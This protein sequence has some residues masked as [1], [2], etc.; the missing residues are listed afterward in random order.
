MKLQRQAQRVGVRELKASLSGHLRR[1]RE[2]ESITVTD[3]G[4]PVAKLIPAGMPPGLE[5]M[6]REGRLTWSG[7]KPDLPR[8][9]KLLGTGPTAG[10]IVVRMRH[11][12]DDA[13]Y[14]AVTSGRKGRARR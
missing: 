8:P 14:R 9:I 2:G 7:G 13:V 6:I 1:V 5:R 12:R 3:R 11:E 10:E 4:E